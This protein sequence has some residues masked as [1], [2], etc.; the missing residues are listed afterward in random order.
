MGHLRRDLPKD[1]KWLLCEDCTMIETIVNKSSMYNRLVLKLEK[2]AWVAF[3]VTIN[4]EEH[5][6]SICN[7]GLFHTTS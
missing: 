1:Y 5:A 7:L 3:K 2:I 4:V 6:H